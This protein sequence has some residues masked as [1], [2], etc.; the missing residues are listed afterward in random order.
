VP[1]P[2]DGRIER[3][4]VVFVGLDERPI[5]DRKY[6]RVRRTQAGTKFDS[7]HESSQVQSG[8]YDEEDSDLDYDVAGLAGIFV[9]HVLVPRHGWGHCFNN[10]S[11]MTIGVSRYDVQVTDILAIAS[12]TS[13]KSAT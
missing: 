8:E 5:D 4:D 10:I 1:Q 12:T 11:S 6:G 3:L 2:L 7:D 9:A 13:P